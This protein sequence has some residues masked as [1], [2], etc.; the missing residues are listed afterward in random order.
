MLDGM[1]DGMLDENYIW[2]SNIPKNGGLLDATTVRLTDL[3]F[4]RRVGL[5]AGYR[6][7]IFCDI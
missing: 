5:P 7:V 2:A 4:V 6:P 3:R 1:L